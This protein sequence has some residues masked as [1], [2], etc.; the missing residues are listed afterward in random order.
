MNR[1]CLSI[2]VSC[3]LTSPAISQ[4][5]LKGKLVTDSKRPIPG[6]RINIVGHTSSLTDDNGLFEIPLSAN[7]K[8]G[9]PIRISIEKP[10]WVIYKPEDGDWNAPNIR[11]QHIQTVE[12]IVVREGSPKLLT[13]MKLEKLLAEASSEQRLKAEANRAGSFDVIYYLNKWT[14]DLKV[15]PE[16]IKKQFDKWAK[17]I[18]ASS[19]LEKQGLKAFYRNDLLTAYTSFDKA[20][21]KVRQNIRDA[22]LEYY[23]LSKLSGN[24][25]ADAKLFIEALLRYR[26]AKEI[27]TREDTPKQ[28]IEIENLISSAKRELGT[29]VDPKEGIK[30]LW[31][32][33]EILQNV[34]KTYSP[35]AFPEDWAMTQNS[36]G[37]VLVDLAEE[38]EGAKATQL[39]EQAANAYREALRVYTKDRLPLDWAAVQNNL[40][41]VLR[42]QSTRTAGKMRVELLNQS[43]A[44]LLLS[45]SV[46]K[47]EK[48]P[49]NWVSAQMNFGNVLRERG[50]S[51]GGIRGK[52]ALDESVATYQR[53]YNACKRIRFTGHCSSVL[54]NLAGALRQ[55]GKNTTGQEAIRR[56]EVALLMN[57]LALGERPYEQAPQ[58]WADSQQS[59]GVT[60][61]ELATR[62]DD[63]EAI[64]LLNDA[65]KAFR[66]ILSIR[67]HEQK[68]Q[69]WARTQHAIGNALQFK[70]IRMGG[71][72]SVP[73]FIEA[74]QSYTL[75]L[76]VRKREFFPSAYAETQNGL[77][78]VLYELGIH[79]NGKERLLI[80]QKGEAAYREALDTY[81]RNGD[82]QSCAIVLG[83]LGNIIRNQGVTIKGVEGVS[84]LRQAEGFYQL[85]LEE[86]PREYYRR[87]WA[88]M[89]ANL[90]RTLYYRGLL[91]SGPARIHTLEQATKQ[92][93]LALEEYS[94]EYS[95]R[96]WLQISL[97]LCEAYNE[98]SNNA[99]AERCLKEV[100]A[101][102]PNNRRAF[103]DISFFYHEVVFKFPEA[104]EASRRWLE[105][106]SNDINDW[107]NFAEHHFTVGRYEECEKQIERLMSN[108]DVDI[109]NRLGLWP[110]KIASLLALNKKDRVLGEIEQLLVTV[111]K[112]DKDF[113]VDWTYNGTIRFI[114]Q[115]DK[116]TPFREWLVQLFGAMMQRD[117]DTI[118]RFLERAKG[119]FK[120]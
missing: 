88:R 49:K 62:M 119:S 93:K 1:F 71:P 82:M 70:G 45:L 9:S 3:F 58:K 44:A 91:E 108:P 109:N 90:G 86:Y 110:L 65:L 115:S 17:S 66:S 20:R 15:P 99:A 14:R 102:Y 89:Q 75:A 23:R 29:S 81:N 18:D 37:M 19:D 80:W 10:G 55:Q 28:W 34:L 39:L 11:L 64:S 13:D 12:V 105:H 83:N 8:E 78:A 32:S 7:T 77:G 120:F 87:E 114:N 60:L 51:T 47:P 5:V 30:F 94:R 2:L 16:V 92:Y 4:I 73:L 38:L 42:I 52:Q 84:L 31:E 40:G 79:A 107:V 36:L 97:H 48:H 113:T 101:A 85:A 116:L 104:F 76:T 103:E 22:N 26:D 53:A 35:E 72:Q 96:E 46:Y 41:S 117:R 69:D 61:F 98:L 67:T 25:L 33:V 6:T 24:S 59:L 95:P 43:A 74:E 118:Y 21:L 56:F 112:Q 54:H 100:F 50:N 68:P 106:N 63:K 27:I 111:S 57:Y